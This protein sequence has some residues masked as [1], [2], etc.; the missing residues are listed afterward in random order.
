MKL[1][2]RGNYVRRE[3]TNT[4]F[5]DFTLWGA[6]SAAAITSPTVTILDQDDNDVSATLNA[7]GASVVDSVQAQFDITSVTQY[8]RYRVFVKVTIDSDVVECWCYLDGDL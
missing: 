3:A 2:S 6:S 8:D 1:R 5:V 4:F 7:G